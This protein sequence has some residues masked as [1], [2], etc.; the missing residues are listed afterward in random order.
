[1]GVK[2]FD[3]DFQLQ[4]CWRIFAGGAR[5][6]FLSMT[7]CSLPQG[8][9]SGARIPAWAGQADLPCTPTDHSSASWAESPASADA[10]LK[11]HRQ[12]T[13]Y[14]EQNLRQGVR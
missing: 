13:N 4:V 11:K 5:Q 9:L 2:G 14:T 3:G 1:M 10:S 6:R 12:S 8:L 7:R